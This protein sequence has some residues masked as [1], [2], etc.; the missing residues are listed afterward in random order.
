MRSVSEALF[1]DWDDEQDSVTEPMMPIVFAPRPAIE[2]PAETPRDSS[3]RNPSN[4]P[5]TPF[6]PNDEASVTISPAAEIIE[7]EIAT[8]SSTEH[9]PQGRVGEEHREQASS[10]RNVPNVVGIILVSVQVLLLLRVVLFLFGVDGSSVW[11]GW[12]F[13]ITSIFAKPMRLVLDHIQ[14]LQVLGQ[15]SINY[16]APLL[17]ILLFGLLSRLLVRFLKTLLQSK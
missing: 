14:A 13:A 15:D 12:L 11:V 16:L 17:T 9:E 6:T 7:T 10:W 3:L 1:G 5:T 8:G 2:H 4:I